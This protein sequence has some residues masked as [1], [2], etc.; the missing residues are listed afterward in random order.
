MPTYLYKREDGVTF[1][2]LQKISE[3][4]LNKCP[5]TGLQVKRV[6]TG[7]AGVVYKGSGWY[8]TDYKNK[9]NGKNGHQSNSGTNG[10]GVTDHQGSS[11]NENSSGTGKTSSESANTPSCTCGSSK[12]T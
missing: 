3:K 7:G 4:P 2:V 5:E 9:A 11:P 12:K 1:E 8:V 6:I 10:S